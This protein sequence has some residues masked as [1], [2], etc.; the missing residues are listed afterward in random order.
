MKV[1]LALALLTMS[2]SAYA[3]AV[4]VETTDSQGTKAY[5]AATVVDTKDGRPILVGCGHQFKKPQSKILINGKDLATLLFSEVNDHSDISILQLNRQAEVNVKATLGRSPKE[6]GPIHIYKGGVTLKGEWSPLPEQT[7]DGKR[8]FIR[9]LRDDGM[10]QTYLEGIDFGWSGAPVYDSKD[11][12]IGVV[13]GMTQ[14][15]GS[16]VVWTPVETLRESLAHYLTPSQ[17]SKVIVYVGVLDPKEYNCEGCIKFKEDLSS[18]TVKQ[19]GVEYRLVTHGTKDIEQTQQQ[20]QRSGYVAPTRYPWFWSPECRCDPVIGYKGGPWLLSWLP[21]IHVP[22]RSVQPIP[23]SNDVLV[24]PI[25]SNYRD[26]S[27]AEKT[28]RIKYL[29]SAVATLQKRLDNLKLAPSINGEKGDQGFDGRDGKDGI[30]GKDGTNG[31]D[32]IDDRPIA[33]QI[34]AVSPDGKETVIASESYPRGQPIKLRF[35]ESY[36]KSGE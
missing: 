19:D 13:S 4:L 6:K 21:R 20:M 32:G 10:M 18:G 27:D 34:I 22:V 25:P 11:E 36:I 3:Q 14:G 31:K 2:S 35:K 15:E 24:P 23:Q 33:V 29:E 7:R 16:V 9:G 1:F 17:A 28:D 26:V 5:G 12:M 30:N 8:Y